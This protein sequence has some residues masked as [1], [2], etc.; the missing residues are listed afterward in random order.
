M[1]VGNCERRL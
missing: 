1:G